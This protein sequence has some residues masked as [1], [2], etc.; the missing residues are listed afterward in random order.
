MYNQI[1]LLALNCYNMYTSPFTLNTSTSLIEM[2]SMSCNFMLH[3]NPYVAHKRICNFKA[4]ATRASVCCRTTEGER[5]RASDRAMMWQFFQLNFHS[6]HCIVVA[7]KGKYFTICCSCVCCSPRCC[8]CLLML[9]K[10]LKSALVVAKHETHF[11]NLSPPCTRLSLCFSLS[12]FVS[13]FFVR[14]SEVFPFVCASERMISSEIIIIEGKARR[15]T[16]RKE[17]EGEKRRWG[18]QGEE[19]NLCGMIFHYYPAP[20]T[21]FQLGRPTSNFLTVRARSGAIKSPSAWPSFP[22]R[23]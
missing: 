5:M 21:K 18:V 11:I 4:N 12:F 16:Q 10:C 19:W 23:S 1:V 17:A 7:S 2:I 22:A 13:G 9:S 8:C 6:F 20:C 14:C 3:K 15:L